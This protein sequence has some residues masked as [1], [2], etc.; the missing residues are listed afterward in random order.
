ML[1]QKI[2]VD[3]LNVLVVFEIFGQPPKQGL[4]LAGGDGEKNP[5]AGL[6]G[7]AQSIAG[8]TPFGGFHLFSV[9]A[10]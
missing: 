2:A 8:I 1:G 3:D 7:L 5:V 6:N 9:E 4:R 10:A